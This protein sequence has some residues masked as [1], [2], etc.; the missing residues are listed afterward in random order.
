M[1]V[2]TEY[3][4]IVRRGTLS[5]G[6]VGVPGAVSFGLDVTAMTGIWTAMLIAIADKSAHR[7]DKVFAAKVVAGVLAG[8]GAYLTGSKIA[9]GLLN[10]IPGAGTLAA[11]GVNSGLNALF[12]YRFGH[13]MSSL[14]D[15]GTFDTSDAASATATVLTVI[16]GLPSL[17]EI[18]DFVS[19]LKH[20]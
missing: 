15:K 13:A 4:E 10:L 3:R 2:K 11:M 20:A 12:T 16:V 6:A 8:V 9:V 5:A 17:N 14:F 19:M 1:A 18:S 7:T